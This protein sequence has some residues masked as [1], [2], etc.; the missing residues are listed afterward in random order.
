M[1]SSDCLG[2]GQARPNGSDERGS[3]GLSCQDRQAALAE[4]A[5][6]LSVCGLAKCPFGGD[7]ALL[8]LLVDC[9]GSV[10]SQTVGAAAVEATK[11]LP[12]EQLLEWFG[13]PLLLRRLAEVITAVANGTEISEEETAA[14]A[15]AADYAS[16]NRPLRSWDRLDRDQPATDTV[17][18]HGSADGGQLEPDSLGAPATVTPLHAELATTPDGA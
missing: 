18:P 9:V 7:R 2:K 4:P 16:G 6:H 5:G 11:Q 17:E 10:R 1:E 13:E 8:S 14:L 15:L 12:W 3:H